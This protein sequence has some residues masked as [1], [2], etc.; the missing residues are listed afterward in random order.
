MSRRPRLPPV[1]PPV[2]GPLGRLVNATVS[3]AG[4]RLSELAASIPDER[5][6]RVMRSPAR[7]PIIE[8]IF[9]LM[10]RYLDR[11]RAT[12]V[13]LAIRWRITRDEADT[14]PD[15]YDLVIAERRCRVMRDESGPPPLV[16]ITIEAGELLLVA[17]GR[18]TPMQT[19]FAGRL[20]LR[21]DITQAARLAGLFRIPTPGRTPPAGASPPRRGQSPRTR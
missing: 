9:W 21:G 11:S 8:T 10:P 6:R 1:P 7:R 13:N 20:G 12:G 3:Q 2:A 16:T 5:L 17:T 19:Y 4:D 14:D 18:S 15:V